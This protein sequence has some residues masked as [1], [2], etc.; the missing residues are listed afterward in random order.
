[1]FAA[2]ARE[3]A[4][5]RVFR[6]LRDGDE[7]LIVAESAVDEGARLVDQ[8]LALNDDLISAQRSLGRRQR[9]LEA[10]EADSRAASERGARLEAITLGAFTE[11]DLEAALT[12][13]LRMI[14]EAVDGSGGR[15][16]LRDDERGSLE[17]RA[18]HGEAPHD[19]DPSVALRL[20]GEVVGVLAVRADEVD[21]E[22]L[23]LLAERTVLAIAH[24]QLRERESRLAQAL[25]RA[26]LP[27][28]LPEHER[29]QLCWRHRAV[30]RDADVGGDF[31]DALL[32]DDGRVGLCIGDVTGKGLR[33]AATMGRLRSTL[34]AYALDGSSP[35]QVLN[36]LDR[37]MTDE[38]DM[39]TAIYLVLDPHTG[40][41]TIALAGHPPPL[42]IVPGAEPAELDAGLSP[43]LGTG[44]RE[45]AEAPIT[46]PPGA[47]LL[48]YTDGLVEH[49]R[50]GIIE[51]MA[52]LREV[53]AGTGAKLGDLCD[54]VIEAM[55]GD[56][57][58]D[59][60][61]LLAV[62]RRR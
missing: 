54:T 49:R 14:V 5:D 9:E 43:P 62:E 37:F 36:R 35:A 48:L 7:V 47:R 26:L 6:F 29:L 27:V 59:D 42:L 51:G 44:D 13:A 53:A 32:L 30:V 52:R 61:A 55:E 23:D 17:L 40:E 24:I 22:L 8:V 57:Y 39:A 25:Q 34:R 11:R 38:D 4:A 20:G 3:L 2:G 41:G 12:Q 15:I 31:Y 1:V 19:D 16:A 45:R 58:A 21:A 10:A 28:R 46:L 33:A 56:G 18:E 60:V 50:T